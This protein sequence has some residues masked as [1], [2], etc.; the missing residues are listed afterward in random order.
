MVKSLCETTGDEIELKM[1]DRLSP[2]RFVIHQV[3]TEI[4]K[5]DCDYMFVCLCMLI[6]TADIAGSAINR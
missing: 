2:L 1:Y 4:T 3:L 5:I 6:S